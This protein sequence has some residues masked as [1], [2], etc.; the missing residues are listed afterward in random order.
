[1]RVRLRGVGRKCGNFVLI[2]VGRQA[3][4]VP[5]GTTLF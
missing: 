1:L 4:I 5:V 2:L 3:E